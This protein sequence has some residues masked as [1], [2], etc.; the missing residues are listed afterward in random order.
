MSANV[1][2][3]F[4][5]SSFLS[6][7]SSSYIQQNMPTIYTAIESLVPKYG[8][9]T[10]T[11]SNYLNKKNDVYSKRLIFN[12]DID[13]KP[14]V[15]FTGGSKNRYLLDIYKQKKYKHSFQIY[16]N[17]VG[18]IV[19]QYAKQMVSVDKHLH[20]FTYDNIDISTTNNNQ[21]VMVLMNANSNQTNITSN[22][23]WV[24]IANKSS[25]VIVDGIDPQN[26]DNLYIYSSNGVLLYSPTKNTTTQNYTSIINNRTSDVWLGYIPT[27]FGES[28]C[29]HL[30]G[31]LYN[32]YL[33]ENDIKAAPSTLINW[34]I[35]YVIYD[36]KTHDN[37]EL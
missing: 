8:V 16:K 9:L 22:V 33:S 12:I 25:V 5:S 2:E 27:V 23:T 34:A 11:Y 31:E 29:S 6:V 13:N 30:L 37:D 17:I 14:Y 3:V 19:H 15:C 35:Q 28:I 21:N 32:Y 24:P 7:A 18:K 10:E 36:Y 4:A 26:G 1:S 20:I